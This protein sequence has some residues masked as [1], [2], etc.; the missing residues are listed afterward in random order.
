[1]QQVTHD[2]GLGSSAEFNPNNYSASSQPLTVQI[3]VDPVS[4]DL[5][6]VNYGDGHT[7]TMSGYGLKTDIAVPTHTISTTVLQNRL[8]AIKK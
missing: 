5:L 7:E 1:M 8:E 6:A 3:I 2:I 4:R